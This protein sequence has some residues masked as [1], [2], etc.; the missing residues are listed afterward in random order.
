MDRGFVFRL[1]NMYVDN[2]GPG[3]PKVGLP[4]QNI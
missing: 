3:D 1:I 4:K 2:F